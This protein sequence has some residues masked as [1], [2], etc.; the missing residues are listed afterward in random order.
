MDGA[1]FYLSKYICAHEE[2][3]EERE[4]EREMVTKLKSK[5]CQLKTSVRQDAAMGLFEPQCYSHCIQ[6]S[7]FPVFL[8]LSSV[9]TN[10]YHRTMQYFSKIFVLV[11]CEAT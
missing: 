7:F 6:S 4:R 3:G 5:Y 2:R 9:Q 1:K 11:G 10:P 8:P